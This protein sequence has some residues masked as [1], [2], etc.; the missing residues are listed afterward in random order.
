MKKQYNMKPILPK[1]LKPIAFFLIFALIF[2]E[3]NW[4]FLPKYVERNEEY[5]VT[6]TF[7]QFYEMDRDTVDVLMIGT[8]VPATGFCP[9]VLYDNYGI[10]A[11]N[12]GSTRQSVLVSY[13]WLKEALRF[14]KPKVVMFDTKFLFE[15]NPGDP[16][17]STEASI[18][19][20]MDYMQWS[21]VKQ[22]AVKDICERDKS[23]TYLSYVFP[24]L[25]YH[26]RWE[27]L[28]ELD[29]LSEGSLSND[30]KGY[31]LL[32][33]YGRKSFDTYVQSNT[34]ERCEMVP[35]MREY[36]DKIV[37]LCDEE[38][39]ELVL[40]TFPE[41]G[42]TDGVNNTL[43]EYAAQK[44]LDYYNL[45]ED[46]LFNSIGAHLPEENI[47]GHENFLGAQKMTNYV[48]RILSEKYQVQP[49]VS[50]KWEITREPYQRMIKDCELNYCD[51]LNDFL[52]KLSDENYTV[53]VSVVEGGT[54][55][56]D[57]NTAAVFAALGLT[58]DPVLYKDQSYLAII[59][60]DGNVEK[61]GD[62]KLSATGA[63]CSGRSQ[64]TVTSTSRL[65][66]GGGAIIID[67][68]EYA[69]SDKG[70]SIVVYD[71]ILRKVVCDA[72]YAPIDEE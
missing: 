37:Q 16:F 49:R 31:I 70:M 26:D 12:L 18:R 5:P 29:M 15:R 10:T 47:V 57:A 11:Y 69:E 45:C 38:G 2:C 28:D 46:S 48:G 64:Y 4:V 68:E 14:Q 43:S 40:M 8:S 33:Q 32:P 24:L 60:D 62:E 44:G 23:Q 22:E 3:L 63:F 21:S 67:G 19:K 27:E 25:R 59:K 56:G 39:I 20:S 66:G 36:L 13:Y 54:G 35:L 65:S 42:M 30:L 6:N 61:A 34:E 50:E 51:G 17:N 52:S 41:T 71:N 53:F 72:F 9:Q 58:F 7:R 1:I 55:A